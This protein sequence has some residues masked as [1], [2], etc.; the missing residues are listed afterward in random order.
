MQI[1][2]AANTNANES[3]KNVF[4][5]SPLHPFPASADNKIAN[6]VK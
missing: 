4:N 3:Q 6:E 2:I 5:V 1:I